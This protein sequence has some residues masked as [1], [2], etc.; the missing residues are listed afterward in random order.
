MKTLGRKKESDPKIKLYKILIITCKPY[1]TSL[2][3]PGLD[4]HMEVVR[5]TSHTG[6]YC[7]EKVKWEL[8]LL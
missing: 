8:L 2:Q 1:F 4:R 7:L 3:M 6:L 5:Q